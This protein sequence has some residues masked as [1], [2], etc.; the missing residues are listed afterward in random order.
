VAG[1]GG[2]L[3]AVGCG[4]QAEALS[5][6]GG[7]GL[8]GGN[9]G[10]TSGGMGGDS[11]STEVGQ[12]CS[13]DEDCGLHP[14]NVCI[15]PSSKVGVF[16]S[17][18]NAGTEGGGVAGGYCTRS[19]EEDDECPSDSLCSGNICLLKC[20][21]GAP[22]LPALDAPLA[23]EKC[24]GREDLMCVPTDGEKALCMPNCGSDAACGDLFCDPRTG[25]CSAPQRTGQP[26]GAPCDP[27][28]DDCAGKCLP[29][30]DPKLPSG[31][32]C[33]A[34]CTLGGVS[35]DECGGAEL[36]I[37]AIRSPFD[38]SGTPQLG[39]VGYCA[40]SCTYHAACN[41]G[42]G[43]FCLDLG[44]WDSDGQGYCMDATPCPVGDE[45]E[46]GDVCTQA[47]EA[48]YCLDDDGTGALLIPFDGSAGAGGAGGSG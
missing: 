32:V 3:A 40:A 16:T 6:A 14:G 31:G 24:H 1:V 47:G 11:G 36:G 15:L 10:G 25:V 19:C 46:P 29:L 44:N 41:N 42:G 33:A 5:G 20:D 17:F 28:E 45:C 12:S 26:N 4:V 35:G 9:G 27:A 22:D 2:V 30:G 37:C 48:S 13:R 7:F 23:S 18:W 43:Q 38:A 8:T 34:A 21:Y 39:D